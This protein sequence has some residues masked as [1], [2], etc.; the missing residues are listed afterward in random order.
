V[1]AFKNSPLKNFPTLTTPCYRSTYMITRY[2][3]VY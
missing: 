2:N 3:R 1:D